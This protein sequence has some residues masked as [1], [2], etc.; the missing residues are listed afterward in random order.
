MST[1]GVA[2]AA[3]G[4]RYASFEM[5]RGLAALMVVVFHS[6]IR[7]HRD[8]EFMASTSPGQA[9][10]VTITGHL[11]F[12][13]SIFFAISG[14]CICAA[15]DRSFRPELSPRRYFT[16]RLRRIFPPYWGAMALT[17]LLLELFDRAGVAMYETRAMSGGPVSHFSFAQWLGNL[18]LTEQ[19]RVHF[20]GGERVTWLVGQSW[21]LA[22]EEQ[23]YL[24]MGLLALAPA[25]A[26]WPLIGL[27][28]L[29][30]GMALVT[31][32]PAL[33]GFIVDGVW[34]DFLLGI[35]MYQAIHHA[36][37]WLRR[38]IIGAILV[39]GVFSLLALENPDMRIANVA[40]CAF[41]LAAIVLYRWDAR[42]YQSAFT[43]PLT[44][45]GRMSYSLYLVHMPFAIAGASLFSP[46][47][48][49][50]GV[51]IALCIAFGAGLSLLVGA[52]FH[53]LVERHFL[54][55]PAPGS[56][57]GARTARLQSRGADDGT[58]PLSS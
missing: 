44:R 49:T 38:A 5:W 40:G 2:L 16:R 25:V 9:L 26:R 55:S 4:N 28:T 48:F 32:W 8:P 51:R 58:S 12:G 35:L 30:S 3:Q 11:F 23:F 27:V 57:E 10:V 54:A 50:P 56:L 24:V 7:L 45:L 29:V 53:H 17:I 39:Y 34:V 36:G 21:T 6:V 1:S 47:R 42:I 13:V 14:Y 19:W 15:L 22:Y 41:T 20:I 37:P 31:E 43:R 46:E 52:T 18:T 33:S